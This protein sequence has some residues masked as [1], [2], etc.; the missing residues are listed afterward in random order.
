MYKRQTNEVYNGTNNFFTFTGLEEGQ[1]RFR[2]NLGF[3]GGKY[4]ELSNSSYVNY[5]P[6]V[7]EES[8]GVNFISFVS[9]IAIILLALVVRSRDGDLVD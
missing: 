6:E 5:I 2:A 1:N 9:V 8:N 4:S 7:D 3:D